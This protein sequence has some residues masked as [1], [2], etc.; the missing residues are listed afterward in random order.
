MYGDIEQYTDIQ[1]TNVSA[2]AAL[3]DESLTCPLCAG[4]N[5][6]PNA[7][8]L[9]IHLRGYHMAD[10]LI[11]PPTAAASPPPQPAASSSSHPQAMSVTQG[12]GRSASNNERA[13]T[14][15]TNNNSN[16]DMQSVPS[17]GTEDD[18]ESDIGRLKI[19]TEYQWH[20]SYII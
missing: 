7:R 5:V 17:E 16:K 13:C 3:G 12:A 20:L 18:P 19:D 11:L 8:E 9:L 15:N 10:V 1:D 2:M 4:D 6:A 14:D